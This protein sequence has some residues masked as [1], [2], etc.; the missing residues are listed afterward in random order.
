MPRPVITLY[1]PPAAWGIPSLSPFG[2]KVETYLRMVGLPYQVRGGDSRKAPKGKSPWIEEDGRTI[3]DSSDILDHLKAR[4]GDP[5]D[6]DLDAGQRALAV[7][8]R[9][10]LEEHLYWCLVYTRWVEPGG[11]ARNRE[12]FLPLL[13]PVLGGLI[14]GQIRK[15]L[16]AQL[17]AQGV[18]RHARDDIYRRGAEDL[19]AVSVQLGERPYFLGERPTSVDASLFAFT[20]GLWMF[21]A[22]NPLKRQLAALPNLV[23]YTERM[24]A[25]YF[26]DHPPGSSRPAAGA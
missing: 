25:R 22:D 11:L 9:R 15:G 20:S 6:R 12:Y 13:P 1:Q 17:H 16:V 18:G 8:T 14:L 5:L 7:L 4:H 21:P 10:T 3:C 23:A 24:H 19:A 2:T 26:G